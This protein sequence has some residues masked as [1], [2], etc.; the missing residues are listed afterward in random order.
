[1]TKRL[2]KQIFSFN[3]VFIFIVALVFN[4]LY[5][6]FIYSTLVDLTNK[7]VANA[8]SVGAKAVENSI[9]KKVNEVRLAAKMSEITDENSTI[10]DKLDFLDDFKKN[11]RT[12][13]F[14]LSDINGHSC[15]SDGEVLHVQ[16]YE[17]FKKAVIGDTSM[18]EPIYS[19][20]EDRWVT[21][22]AAPVR[23]SSGKIV[24]V[25]VAFYD[26]QELKGLLEGIDI[27]DGTVTFITTNSG[28]IV[29]SNSD[30]INNAVT[31]TGVLDKNDLKLESLRNLQYRAVE[32]EIGDGDYI[33]N[34]VKM[35]ASFNKIENS[36][37]I[38]VTA[39]PD[40]ILYSRINTLTY[41][42]TFVTLVALLI[43]IFMS[44]NSSRLQKTLKYAQIQS[45][46]VINT[47]NVMIVRLD[48]NGFIKDFNSNFAKETGYNQ[49]ELNKLNI[50]DLAAEN[51]VRDMKI[52]IN[53][54]ITEN[55]P[56][57]IDIPILSKDG[58]SIYILWNFNSTYKNDIKKLS[59]EL[60][61][62]N[63]SKLKEYEK[64]IQKI[65]Y[66]DQLTGLNN[67]VYLE[68]Y[69][70]GLTKHEFNGNEMALI[71]LDFDNFKY[72]NDMFGHNEG[73][74]FL[75]SMSERIAGCSNEKLKVC[76]Q[77]GDEFVILY[78]NITEYGELDLFIRLLMSA[79]KEDYYIN[80][81]K[82]NASASIGVSKYPNDADNYN[83]LFKC[84]DI[85]MNSSKETGRDKVSYFNN[86]MKSNIYEII[87]IQN[88]LK[89]AI[90][91]KEFVLYY[92]PQY[93]I[94]TGELYGFEALIRWNHPEKGFISPAK[95]IPQA[96]KNQ[97]IIPIGDWAL[98]E[99]CDFVK[100]IIAMGVENICVSVNVSVVQMMCDNFVEKVNY[101]LNSKNVSP[102][103]IK[104][105]I[106][107]S[108]MMESI[109]DM[110]AKIR[111]LNECGIYFSLDDFGTGYSSLTYLNKI[112]IKVLKIDKSFVDMI[113]ENNSNKEI[114]SSIID[115]AH[116][117]N[118]EVV[119]E[120]IEEYDQLEWLR[121]KGCNVAQGFY[122]GRPMPK[123]KAIK[124][125]G[126][127]MYS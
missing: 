50:F 75:I 3:V 68:E 35:Y 54:V 118:L 101:T 15:S 87:N 26:I 123:D 96:E 19:Y 65:A 61:G 14:Y 63:I 67:T 95:F 59:I 93:R 109:D 49:Y 42:I 89:N 4:L 13:R 73:D 21:A 120:G 88:D 110:L 94:D 10:K 107:E 111:Q 6:R 43:S 58:R 121:N 41:G 126:N 104:L 113:V 20:H 17:F 52:Y 124:E 18:S 102:E 105:E 22:I 69:V 81:V 108:V 40:K 70:N 72:I 12:L 8:V 116:D 2:F 71:Y 115:L 55:K 29:T 77:G 85:A 62:I 79:I 9:D 76:R 64:K 47:A 114:L 31:T 125:L 24:N 28:V 80:N 11:S 38:L 99:A 45:D 119:A 117:I 23:N 78:E 16:E 34:N 5:Y 51:Y 57:E 122:M 83:D 112:P 53:R 56:M 100:D 33:F 74:K 60:I 25:L 66:F 48:N 44:L 127:N 98:E 27:G 103:N 106:T 92:Q 46:V 82:F 86:S 37:W 36:N 32:K 1:M 30:E 84:A 97:L 39:V 7:F 91:N 90:N